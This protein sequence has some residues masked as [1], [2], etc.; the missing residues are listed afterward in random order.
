M[1]ILSFS[2]L[3][4]AF[5]CVLS[6]DG[7]LAQSGLPGSETI[8]G[9]NLRGYTH[10]FIAYA[11]AWVLILGWVVSIARRLGRIEEALKE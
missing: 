8:A 1:K 3:A 6:P 11:V 5:L 2:L 9:Q 7:L 4:F 10:M